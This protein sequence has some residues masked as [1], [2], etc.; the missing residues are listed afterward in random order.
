M[1]FGGAMDPP[2]SV[3]GQPS[4]LQQGEVVTVN[5][6]GTVDVRPSNGRGTKTSIEVPTWYLPSSG[7][8][9]LVGDLDGDPQ[10][11]IV[12]TVL[13]GAAGASVGTTPADGSVTTPKVNASLK[14]SGT[15]G[16]SI[17]ALRALGIDDPDKALAS[18]AGVLRSRAPVNVKDPP[19]NA[20]GDD[21]TNDSSGCAAAILAAGVGGTVIWPRGTY[22]VSGLQPLSGQTWRGEGTHGWAGSVSSAGT[23]LKANGTSQVLLLDN[24]W[25]CKFKDMVIQG[26]AGASK[27]IV[28]DSDVGSSHGSMM[29]RF[30]HVEVWECTVGIHVKGTTA[31]GGTFSDENDRNIYE[32]VII[33]ECGIG[34]LVDS[35]NAQQQTFR[36]GQIG[37]CDLQIEMRAGGLSLN[38]TDILGDGTG[39]QE[40]ISFTTNNNIQQVLLTDVIF[41][42]TGRCLIS[43]A[44]YWPIQGV[45]AINSVLASLDSGHD[46]I[47]FPSSTPF[48]TPR[49]TL[50]HTQVNG[51]IEIPAANTGASI[52]E[53]H[54]KPGA[55]GTFSDHGT[56]T[57]H[58]ILDLDNTATN[59]TDIREKATDG[60]MVAM[61]RKPGDANPR[62]AIDGAG[63]VYFG[64]G[65]AGV[66]MW[67]QRL[68]PEVIGPVLAHW[69]TQPGYGIRIGE[70]ANSYQG[71][72]T[73]N[74]TTGVTVSTNRVTAN[75][76]IYL[77]IQSPSGTVGTPHVSSRSAGTSFTIK[78]TQGTDVSTVAWLIVNPT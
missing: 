43:P 62:L 33:R 9:V 73:L 1:R 49:L 29:H 22:R 65:T 7:D 19:Y 47:Q 44:S 18:D 60:D 5:T 53:I 51:N 27:G 21:V 56:A 52:I 42:G 50:I 2:V 46:S 13:S 10:R 35:A 32:D 69:C 48:N 72:A 15:A 31:F 66:D 39:A 57:R 11:P 26:N 55:Y 3:T 76:R 75:S 70:G 17:E 4:R 12:V 23:M 64:D 20:Q 54:P 16:P 58:Q 25:H 30:E 36:G 77:T 8:R 67:F 41:E 14:P 74:G 40:G 28:I 45:T 6:D 34:L 78:S 59:V 63:K 68:G 71:T 38:G 37:F 24:Q 61:Y